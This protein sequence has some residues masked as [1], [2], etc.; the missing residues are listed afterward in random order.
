[1]M[2]ITRSLE[3][4]KQLFSIVYVCVFFYMSFIVLFFKSEYFDFENCKGLH[5]YIEFTRSITK[6][7]DVVLCKY[8]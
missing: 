4:G 3:S 6:G 8:S 2:R 1:M 7:M 5:Q